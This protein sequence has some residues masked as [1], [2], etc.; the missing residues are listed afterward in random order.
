MTKNN[1]IKLFKK[2]APIIQAPMAGGITTPE[3]VAA[4]SEAGGIGSFG[5]AYT[6]PEEIKNNLRKLKKLTSKPF[7]TNFFIFP[8]I[9]E[10]AF[11]SFPLA[12]K[13]LMELQINNDFTPKRP[14]AP[15]HE[16]LHL[17]LE[18]V[19]SHR[20]T[21]IT[22]HF[23]TPSEKIIKTAKSLGILI[24]VTATN[25]EEAKQIENCGADFIVAQGI[26]AGGHRGTFTPNSLYD[27]RLSAL[28][29]SRL[30]IKNSNLPIISAGGIMNGRDAKKLLER[31]STAVQM[32]TA[33][34]CC[35][36]AGTHPIHK[37]YILNRN[38][39][40]TTLTKGFSGRLA[41]SIE[42]EFTRKMENKETM[43]F[44]LQSKLTKDLGTYCISSETGEYMNLWAGTG[45]KNV[46]RIAAKKLMAT[47]LDEINYNDKHRDT[48]RIPD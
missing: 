10:S 35:N 17:Q 24:G 44:P 11:D 3:L 14:R 30:A 22:F 23:G 39:R 21:L 8:E 19:W 29:L 7:N 15:F 13:A 5:F 9:T 31:G 45:Y 28:E 20:P 26:E 37:D 18:S 47:L 33:F 4:V 43:P 46:Q 12:K 40:A 48:S 38:S 27:D 42:T 1:L 2:R 6:S 41:R 34:L 32:G 25:L 36:E 16:S